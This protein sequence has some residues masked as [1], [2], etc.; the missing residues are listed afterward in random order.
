MSPLP[1]LI[2]LFFFAA[3]AAAVTASVA[4]L[5]GAASDLLPKYGLPKGLIPDSVASYS[6]DEA[7]GAF[8]IHLA[9]TCYVHFGSHLVYYERT[10]TGKL[11]EGAISDLSGVQAKK[12]FLWVYV[13]G[14][15]AHPDQGTIEFQAGFI[16]ESLSASMFDEVPTCGSSVGAQLRGAAGVI[17]ELGL[18]PVAQS[19]EYYISVTRPEPRVENPHSQRT[20]GPSSLLS[21]CRLSPKVP[22]S[23]GVFCCLYQYLVV[24]PGLNGH[25]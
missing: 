16:S 3:A 8:E 4:S 25:R 22:F 23:C 20:A 14:M 19:K 15:V 11:S 13:T 18:L 10:I 12:L 7:T 1:R 24:A 2:L 9:S 6:F 21:R 17:G 5:N